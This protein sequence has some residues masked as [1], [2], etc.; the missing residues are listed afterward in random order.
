MLIVFLY[1]YTTFYNVIFTYFLGQIYF[2]LIF[3]NRITFS[4]YLI[5]TTN[6]VGYTRYLTFHWIAKLDSTF[7][8]LYEDKLERKISDHGF[9]KMTKA[10]EEEN[11]L[12]K[13]IAVLEETI[14]KLQ[15]EELNME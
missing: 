4:K 2:C 7:Q 3:L 13:R 12:Q 10:F 8:N 9:D 14:T 1:Y 5:K 15:E 6:D 11:S